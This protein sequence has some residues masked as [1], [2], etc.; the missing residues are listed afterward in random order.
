MSHERFVQRGAQIEPARA[1]HGEIEPAQETIARMMRERTE[2]VDRIQSLEIELAEERRR[3]SSDPRFMIG[4]HALRKELSPLFEALQ[5]VFGYLD[6]IAPSS[7]GAQ[8][9]DR[10]ARVLERWKQELGSACASVIDVIRDRPGITVSQ[11]AMAAHKSPRTI[12]NI[13]VTINKAG[14]IDKSG[15][16]I[17]L[18]KL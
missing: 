12:Q 15:R 6:A 16:H 18:R 3:T 4:L 14:L 11:I 1:I 17:S 10:Q 5:V 7:N 2:H 9:D 13:I 8:V